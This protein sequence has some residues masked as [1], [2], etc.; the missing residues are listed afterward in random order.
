MGARARAAFAEIV[1]A[2]AARPHP[3]S[4]QPGGAVPSH[5]P[6]EEDASHHAALHSVSERLD[7]VS[8][9]LKRRDRSERGAG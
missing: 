6:R 7:P 1:L 2:G 9:R 8:L 3:V 5:S 4:A